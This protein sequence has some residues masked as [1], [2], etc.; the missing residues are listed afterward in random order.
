MKQGYL[1][2]HI[3]LICADYKAKRDVM[4]KTMGEKFPDGVTWTEPDGGLF[5]WVELP[6][7]MSAKELLPKAIE[8]KV[9][10]VYGQ[11][12]Y[13]HGEGEN[14]LRL[15]Y[16]N[17]SHNNIEEGITRLGALLKENM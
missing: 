1:E 16:C 14:T 3:E 7:H 6:S 12:F 9:A 17:A 15:N 13:P 2:P 11:P 10:Y 5:L 4:L 8:K